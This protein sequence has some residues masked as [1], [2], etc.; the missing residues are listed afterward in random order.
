MHLLFPL[1]RPSPTTAKRLLDHPM[2]YSKFPRSKI[3]YCIIRL[4]LRV[5]AGFSIRFHFSPFVRSFVRWS[6]HPLNYSKLPFSS[7]YD[8]YV[9]FSSLLSSFNRYIGIGIG[10][11]RRDGVW[12]GLIR[13]YAYIHMYMYISSPI[14]S[15]P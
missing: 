2:F 8:L 4:F 13:C 6:I 10:I 14:F 3:T 1:T 15:F 9:L 5:C 11:K 7:P 12:C